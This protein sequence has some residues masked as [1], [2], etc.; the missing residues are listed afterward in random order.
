MR[1]DINYIEKET[2]TQGK[3]DPCR[4]ASM[5][6]DSNYLEKEAKQ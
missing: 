2:Y 5:R 1:C 4:R 3:R 6:C